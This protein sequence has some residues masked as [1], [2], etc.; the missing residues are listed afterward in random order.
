MSRASPRIAVTGVGMVSALGVGA[1]PTFDRLCA[2][3]TGIGELT[4]FDTA[5]LAAK[6]AG[7][8]SGLVV[9]SGSER[10]DALALLAAREAL[11]QAKLQTTG[12][13]LGLVL[14][15]TAAGMLETEAELL[16]S[17]GNAP[18]TWPRARRLLTHPLASAE[19]SLARALGGIEQS[20]TVCSACSSGAL[21]LVV[22]AHWIASGRAERVLAGGV[23]PLCR[24]TF[25]GFGAL[26][27]LDAEA[28][29]PFDISRRGLTLGE[30]AGFLLL[31]SEASV[32]RRG[33]EPLAWFSGWA[34]GAE[35]HHVTHPEEGG[36]RAAELIERALAV[37]GRSRHEVQY[38]NAHGT[39]TPANDAMEARAIARA[40]G[41]A[42]PNVAVS[43]SKG[44]LGHTLGAAGAIEAA[45]CVL[46]LCE[47]RVP[48]TRG[49]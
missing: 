47:G 15:S 44:Q 25:A 21:A 43:S 45:I 9:P 34:V 40:F 4:L 19:R 23:D 7:E 1:K 27:V 8:V 39:G 22:A 20:V 3:D 35:A 46:A 31:E 18:E 42:L 28:C 49:L 48:P 32:A 38:V 6:L 30:G 17:P 24:M 11:S 36:E 5:G 14:G 29:R 12:S 33:V 16:A 2:G 13:R 26:G 41:D 37:A 10:A